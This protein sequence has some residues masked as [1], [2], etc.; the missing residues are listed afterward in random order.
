[1]RETAGAVPTEAGSDAPLF[2]IVVPVYNA[3][4]R[5]RDCLTTIL[6]QSFDD[7]ELIAVDDASTDASCAVLD[8]FADQDP[9]VRVLH[10]AA[11]SGPGAA[12][13]LGI[14]SARG[15][16]VLFVDADDQLTG[17]ALRRIADRIA[18]A[19]SPDVVMFGFAR[20]YPDGAVVPD[21]RSSALAP[22][23]LLYARDRP[24]LL[25]IFP[26]A[27]NKA[28]RLDY[29]HRCQLSFPDGMYEDIPWSYSVLM[30]AKQLATLDHTCYHYRQ[31]GAGNRLSA[32]GSVHRELFG[33][34]DRVFAYL[35]SH[36]EFEDW[37]PLLLDRMFRHVPGVL[38][39]PGRVPREV[40]RQFFHDASAAF[41]KHRPPGYVPSIGPGL[42]IKV[43]LIERDSYP[44]F[45]AAQL[46]NLGRR[47]IRRAD[48]V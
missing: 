21:A 25:E 23:A 28:C 38:D 10:Q 19:D 48:P 17:E 40:H 41:R 42:R 24:A 3:A 1:M 27:W 47:A 15:S 43:R 31:S 34:Y 12:R 4:S 46:L 37:R 9:R 7:L 44:M 45:R 2:T 26:A 35:D 11:N 18:S 33:Q 32:S 16:Y 14:A 6:T 36:S 39:M 13:N 8:E 20:S 29:L 22:E 30:T 5:L